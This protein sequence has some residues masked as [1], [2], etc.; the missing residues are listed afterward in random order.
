MHNSHIKTFI[1]LLQIV[2]MATA[3]QKDITLGNTDNLLSQQ[4]QA[5][6]LNKQ[7]TTKTIDLS[8]LGDNW[9]IQDNTSDWLTATKKEEFLLF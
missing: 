3:C 9:Q 7:E 6:T 5:V 4:L 8:T 1:F 2:F